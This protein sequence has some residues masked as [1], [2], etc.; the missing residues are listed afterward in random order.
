MAPN[1]FS[2]RIWKKSGLGSKT[3]FKK[4][5]K[6]KRKKKKK[7]LLENNTPGG[8]PPVRKKSYGHLF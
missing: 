6:K 8:P 2:M 1:E 3:N 4:R 5:R 7:Y